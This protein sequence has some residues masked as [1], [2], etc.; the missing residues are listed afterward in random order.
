MNTTIAQ[1]N[2]YVAGPDGSQRGP[3]SFE[4]I[5]KY[6]ATGQIRRSDFVW[7]PGAPNWM[8]A[9]GIPNLAFPSKDQTAVKIHT[10]SPVSTKAASGA[11]DDL[12]IAKMSSVTFFRNGVRRGAVAA[13]ILGIGSV[14][15]STFGASWFIGI[16]VLWR[17]GIVFDAAA[18]VAEVAN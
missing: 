6:A 13:A 1:E 14:A 17:M 10:E 4:V 8:E 12:V 2:W 18:R 5:K 16:P 15:G 11:S 7:K 3:F 9:D